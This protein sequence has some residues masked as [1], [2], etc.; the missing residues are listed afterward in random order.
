[1]QAFLH[2]GTLDVGDAQLIGADR[3]AHPPIVASQSPS[4]RDELA[5]PYPGRRQSV[6]VRRIRVRVVRSAGESRA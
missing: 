2:G 3:L 1:V 4:V 6:S 5:V